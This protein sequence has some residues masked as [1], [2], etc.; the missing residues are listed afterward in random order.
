MYECGLPYQFR[1]TGN[2]R[3]MRSLWSCSI[4][5]PGS[6]T[7]FSQ[8]KLERQETRS[9]TFDGA[10]ILGD[11]GSLALGIGKKLCS[12]PKAPLSSHKSLNQLEK[13]QQTFLAP[14]SLGEV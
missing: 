3:K 11:A 2:P 9:A 5:F 7:K 14:E 4:T 1:T 6:S 8:E 12:L 13:G 10:S